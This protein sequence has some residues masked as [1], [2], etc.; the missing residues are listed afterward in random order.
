MAGITTVIRELKTEQ[1]IVC[2]INNHSI[3][4]LRFFR[5]DCPACI[6]SKQQYTDLATKLSNTAAFYEVDAINVQFSQK[7]P[8][9]LVVPTICVFNRH[10]GCVRITCGTNIAQLE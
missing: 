1:E 7:I 3:T 8:R 10:A 6:S 5:P 9:V 4:V 2:E